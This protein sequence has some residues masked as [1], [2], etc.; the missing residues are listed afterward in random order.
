MWGFRERKQ[1][2]DAEKEGKRQFKWKKKKNKT[3]KSSEY[4]VK[5]KEAKRRNL[6]FRENLILDAETRDKANNVYK[7]DFRHF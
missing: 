3:R 6:C 5:E 4:K 1:K 2:I 7:T